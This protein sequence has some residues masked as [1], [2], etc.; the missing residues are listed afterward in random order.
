M[1]NPRKLGGNPKK[2]KIKKFTLCPIS[3]RLHVYTF[4]KMK[5]VPLVVSDLKPTFTPRTQVMTIVVF[6]VGG[7]QCKVSTYLK[8]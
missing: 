7:M 6:M 8:A 5:N 4:L 2:R 3:L 1:S